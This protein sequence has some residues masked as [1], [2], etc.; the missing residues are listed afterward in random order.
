MPRKLPAALDRQ[1]RHVVRVTTVLHGVDDVVAQPVEVEPGAHRRLAQPVEPAED[2]PV[3]RS[4]S[5]SVNSS[6]R[7]FS[8]SV[9]RTRRAPVGG[10]QPLEVARAEP[11][12]AVRRY[13]PVESNP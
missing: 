7:A 8:G 9:Q 3:R 2:A 4:T 10:Q 1:H 13:S 12:E 5:P 11:L 6:S